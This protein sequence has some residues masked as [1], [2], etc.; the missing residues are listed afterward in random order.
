MSEQRIRQAD[1]KFCSTCGE[2]IKEKAEICP[3][4]GVRQTGLIGQVGD[5]L[6]NS[7]PNGKS[8]I[9][10]ALLAF[11]LGGFGAHKFYLGQTGMGILYLLFCWTFIPAIIA[12]VEFIL[13]LTMKDEVFN[14]RY[15]GLTVLK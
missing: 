12:L 14:V 13:L 11:F 2:I 15:G 3:K 6:T 5:S 10:A 4:C 8:R 7:A 1:E 9:A